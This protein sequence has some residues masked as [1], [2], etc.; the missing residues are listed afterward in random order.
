[1]SSDSSIFALVFGVSLILALF[2]LGLPD[3]VDIFISARFLSDRNE[4]Q[5]RE[6]NEELKK[7][8]FVKS[9]I[10]DVAAGDD[11]ESMTIHC[12]NKMKAMVVFGSEEYGAM[13]ESSYS[14]YHEL[15]YANRRNIHMIVI[16]MCEEWPPKP[17]RGDIH[18]RGAQQNSFILGNKGLKKLRWH[19]REWN[20]PEC[21][22]EVVEAFEKLYPLSISPSK[23][24]RKAVIER[25][26]PLLISDTDFGTDGLDVTLHQKT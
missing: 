16:Q 11:F 14:S 24:V 9:I 25:G 8:N 3:V 12:L 18:G 5:A 22:K 20:A 6:L 19:R 2:S 13:T 4:A 1:M 23:R 21:A 17:T 15:K 7:L 26:R 10:V